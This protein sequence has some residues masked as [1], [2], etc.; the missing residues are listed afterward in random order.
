MIIFISKDTWFP[1]SSLV[2]KAFVL[3]QQNGMTVSLDL[4]SY[5][6]VEAN[7][8]FLKTIIRQYKPVVFANEEE[9]RAFTGHD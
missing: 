4:A 5:N 8:D 3:A 1:T 7:L 9:A 6:V 2:E